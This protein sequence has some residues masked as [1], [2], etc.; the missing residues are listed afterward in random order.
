[1]SIYSKKILPLLITCACKNSYFS[2]L[3]K[4]IIPQ[5]HGR[6]IEIGFGSGLNTPFYNCKL[7]DKVYAV[8][9]ALSFS[10]L[11]NK[12]SINFPV[13]IYNTTAENLPFEDNFFDSAVCTFSFCS[14]NDTLKAVSELKRV[15]KTNSKIYFCEHSISHNNAIARFQ[16]TINPIWKKVFGGCNL[17]RDIKSCLNNFNFNLSELEIISHGILNPLGDI[18]LGIATKK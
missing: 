14:I 17:N 3:R 2:E 6:V 10:K 16:N 1:M 5:A 12:E 13:E 7:I 18:Q 8:E 9:P 4:K 15:I 11:F